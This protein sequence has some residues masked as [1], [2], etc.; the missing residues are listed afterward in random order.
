MAIFSQM[1]RIIYIIRKKVETLRLIRS[2]VGV[3]ERKQTCKMTD[4]WKK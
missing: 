4:P 1:A 3:E 2:G